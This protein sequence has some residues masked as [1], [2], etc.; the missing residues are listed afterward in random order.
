[1]LGGIVWVRAHKIG[2]REVPIDGDGNLGVIP[3]GESPNPEEIAR[4]SNLDDSAHELAPEPIL[5]G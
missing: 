4:W 2:A 5:D 3:T 1:M